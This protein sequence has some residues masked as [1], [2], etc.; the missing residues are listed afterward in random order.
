[1]I[2]FIGC[3]RTFLHAWWFEK[4]IIVYITTIPFFPDWHKWLCL[5]WVWLIPAFQKCS[6]NKKPTTAGWMWAREREG[7]YVK[8]TSMCCIVGGDA[9]ISGTLYLICGY[10]GT[11]MNMRETPGGSRRFGMSTLYTQ[12]TIFL[13]E[14]WDVCY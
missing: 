2:L 4:C 13:Q 5:F 6:Q 1:M 9:S 3:T 12:W 8:M 7:S 11:T 14:R 10:Q